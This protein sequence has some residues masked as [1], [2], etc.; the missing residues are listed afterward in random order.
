MKNRFLM[1]ILQNIVLFPNQEIKLEFSNEMSKTIVEDALK[2]DDG[3]LVIVTPKDPENEVTSL[4]D[5]EKVGVLSQIKNSIDIP[6]G[7]LRVTLRGTKRVKISNLSIMMDG[8]IEVTT[9]PIENPIYNL[10]EELAYSRKLKNLVKEYVENDRQASNTILNVIK[11]MT[12]LSK[13]TDMIAASL[14]FDLKDKS[15]LYKETNYYKRANHL[16]TL[17]SNGIKSLELEQKIEEEIHEKYEKSEKEIMIREKIKSLSNELGIDSDKTSECEE[18]KNIIDKLKIDERIKKSMLREVARFEM[19]MDNSPEYGSLRTHLE[20]VTSLPW[21]KSSKDESDIEKIDEQLNGLH[22]GLGKAKERI[23]EYMILKKMNKNLPSPI[24]C[25]IG[26]PGTGKTTFAR[27][28][29][30]STHREFVKVSVGGLNDSSEL[31]G[32]RRTYIGAGPGKIMEGIRKC[33]VNN[34]IILIDEVDKILKDYKGDPSSVLLEI[35]DQSQ[36]RE[37]VDN[38]VTE[39]FD[40]SNVLFILTANDESKIPRALFDRLEVIEVASYTLFDKIEIAKNY[41]LPRLGKEYGFDYKKI[42]FTDDVI[43]RIVEDYTKEAGVRDLERKISSIIRKILI[44]GLTKTVT[45]KV[46]DLEKYLGNEKYSEYKNHYDTSGVAN[47]PAFTSSGGCVINIEVS[48]LPGS[49]KIVTTGSLG[50][51]MQESATVALSYLK[52]NIK[53][54]KI[55]KKI[56]Q[57]TIHVHALDGATPKEGPSAGLAIAMA[58]LSMALDQKIP[59]DCAFTGEISLKGRILQVGGIKEKLI[60][61]YNAGI[62]TMYIPT[63]NASDLKKVPEKIFKE[64]TV[65]AVSSFTEVYIDV[66]D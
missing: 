5:I 15:A 11:N 28:L 44:K 6:N 8:Q 36:N 35:L 33:G 22:Y 55:D 16:V 30:S 66:F 56:L 25:L 19:T 51:L 59:A 40:L 31:I 4:T 14:D 61:A 65:K 64:M 3:Y 38:Y 2:E 29:A 20:F 9:E 47:V 58:T 45:I 17:L 50:K 24:L 41:T 26:P 13:L 18:F 23:E 12:N 48:S 32:H 21:N 60:S 39:P 10:E 62:R 63:D 53:Q 49:E 7:N 43:A 34:P 46:S 52:S 54:F 37:F 1:L 57:E 27:E 42:K